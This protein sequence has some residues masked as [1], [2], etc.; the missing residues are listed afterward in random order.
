VNS[1]TNRIYVT[2]A[3]RFVSSALTG[4]GG[5][6]VIDGSTNSTTT[7]IDP[8]AITDIPAPLAVDPVTDNIYVV[9]VAS[10]S[11]TVIHDANSATPSITVL[12]SPS[13]ARVAERASQVFRVIVT[14]DP[15]NLGVTW[16]L[17]SPCDFGPACRGGLTVTSSFSATY[18]APSTTA[19]NPITITAISSADAT[20]MAKASVTVTA[21]R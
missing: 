1:L 15:K 16:R 13:S 20:K 7:V 6:T 2:N 21:P 4:N 9:N 14:N 3:N 17:A 19:G 11:V 8:K 10:N 5:V 12:L 18:T